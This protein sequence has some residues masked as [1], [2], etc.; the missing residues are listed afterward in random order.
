MAGFLCRRLDWD[1][2]QAAD[3]MH[4]ESVSPQHRSASCVCT[5]LI[6]CLSSVCTLQLSGKQNRPRLQ[7]VNAVARLSEC[8]VYP[9]NPNS[10][11]VARRQV[12]K[13]SCPGCRKRPSGVVTGGN[14]VPKG[15]KQAAVQFA[16]VRSPS[17]SFWGCCSAQMK[18]TSRSLAHAPNLCAPSD[19]GCVFRLLSTLLNFSRSRIFVASFPM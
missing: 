5:G 13:V 6:I 1:I 15:G 18:D 9:K 16:R 7:R 4:Y 11:M 19:F 2:N 3:A 12:T 17:V 14:R 10:G 8:A